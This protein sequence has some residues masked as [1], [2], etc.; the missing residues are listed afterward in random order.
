[1]IH[2]CREY[3]DVVVVGADEEATLDV[4]ELALLVRF[5][6]VGECEH[7][8]EHHW[9]VLVVAM[10]HPSHSES[11]LK[12]VDSVMGDCGG[13]VDLRIGDVTTIFGTA[14]PRNV[15]EFGVECVDVEK[16]G[17][18]ELYGLN[19]QRTGCLTM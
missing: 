8:G 11:V 17:V 14:D 18:K 3:E 5:G 2:P 16:D 10:C 7:G 4:E 15:E 13:N 6:Q 12:G 19:S 1:M 9:V